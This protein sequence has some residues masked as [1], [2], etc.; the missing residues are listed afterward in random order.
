[1]ILIILILILIK[2]FVYFI[3]NYEETKKIN[4]INKD[5]FIREDNLE[6]Y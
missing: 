3:N 4:N 2:L 5:I 1:M 6:I